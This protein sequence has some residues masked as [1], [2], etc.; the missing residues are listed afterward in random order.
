LEENAA[1]AKLPNLNIVFVM[2]AME[3]VHHVT[4]SVRTV[5]VGLR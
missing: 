5:C 2:L 1:D 3:V 4:F